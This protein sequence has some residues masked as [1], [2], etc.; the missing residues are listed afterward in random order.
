MTQGVKEAAAKPVEAV[1]IPRVKGIDK[2]LQ[3]L[4]PLLKP[5]KRYLLGGL[6]AL[7]VSSGMM[8][9]LGWGL[10]NIVDQGF[11]DKTGAF[12]DYALS[13]LLVVILV[14]AGASYAR[15]RIVNLVA[16]R[17]TTDLRRQIYRHL[18]SLDPA[19]FE[20]EKT[21]DH[22]SRINADTTVLQ[23]VVTSNLPS[24]LRHFLMLA[25]G[26]V[27]LCFVSPSMTGIVMLA[28]PLV[29]GPMIYFGRRVR[30]KSRDTQA[31][32]GDIGSYTQETLSGMQTIQSFGYE[33]TAERHFDGLAEDVFNTAVKYIHARAFLIAFVIAIVFGAIGLVLWSGGHQVLRG[34]LSAGDLSAFIFYAAMVAGAVMAISEAMSDFNRASGAADRILQLLNTHPSI[35]PVAHGMSLPDDPSGYVTFENVTF[36][37]PTRPDRLALDDVS[38]T[39]SAGEIVALVGPSGAGKTTIFQ[40]LQRF[41]D[42]KSGF[43][44]IDGVDIRDVDPRDVRRCLSVVAQD[45]VI[46]S[47]SVAE[48]I[49]MG[50]PAASDA[51]VMYA[52]EQAQAHQFIA[53]LPEGYDTMVGERGNRLSGG[54]RQRIAIARALLKDP[55]ILLLDEATSALDSSNEQAVYAA[56]RELMKGRT[57][58]VI[59]HRLSTVQDADR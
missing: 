48:N 38:F 23:L 28:V 6:G 3:L 13:W 7:A 29:V 42:P 19:F 18:L 22:V 5:Y 35:A 10:K 59:A 33:T 46:F 9:A 40:L 51:E 32:V 15:F 58:I 31:R 57:T 11:D 43:I 34:E 52:A 21:G 12:L 55:A 45:P 36:S 1:E 25:G 4:W 47:M 56:L 17:V 49:R 50:K 44:T 16:E 14:M 37:Y 53:D 26:I 2:P 20:Q 8:L 41:Y 30:S 39:L 54:Q 24:A 27:M